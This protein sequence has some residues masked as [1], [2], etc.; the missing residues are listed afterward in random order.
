MTGVAV[1]GRITPAIKVFTQYNNTLYAIDLVSEKIQASYPLPAEGYTCLLDKQKN[2]LYISIWGGRK[3]LPFQTQT[4]KFLAAISVGDHPN[5]MVLTKNGKY[6]FVANA[7]DNSVSVIETAKGK[8][9]VMNAQ[10]RTFTNPPLENPFLATAA[11][12]ARLREETPVIFLDFHAEAT[13][14]KIAM[15]WHLDG[16]V[17]AVVGTHTHVQTADERILPNGT[18]HLTDAGMCGPEDSVIGSRV[19]PVLQRFR[20]SMPA[21]FFV[22]QGPVRVSGACIDVDTTTGRALSIIRVSERWSE[23]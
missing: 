20:T 13:S 1:R 16:V 17:S 10:G 2:I 22:A 4:K 21:R 19:E 6:L 8:V 14:E 11:E 18:A 3:V 9:A 7:N 15:G 12:A 5:E 23:P